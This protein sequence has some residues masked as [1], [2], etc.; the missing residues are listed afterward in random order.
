MTTGTAVPLGREETLPSERCPQTPP[1]VT[2]PHNE[3][4]QCPRGTWQQE[5]GG[6]GIF[7]W[8]LRTHASWK[9]D[10]IAFL[11][12]CKEYFSSRVG[13]PINIENIMLDAE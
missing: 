9:A 12:C 11:W 5:C 7:R 4:L 3:R 6:K 13:C 8:D 1:Y 10:V 2:T